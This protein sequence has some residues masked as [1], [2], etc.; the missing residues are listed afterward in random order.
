MVIIVMMLIVLGVLI[1][2][3]R[4]GLCLGQ[5]QLWLLLLLL[6]MGLL[7]RL[8]LLLLLWWLLLLAPML[9]R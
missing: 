3:G 6:G 8:E 9:P 5:L 7:L 4:P 2:H 1:R